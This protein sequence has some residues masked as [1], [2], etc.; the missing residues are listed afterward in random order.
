MPLAETAIGLDKQS[1]WEKLEEKK[2]W[3]EMTGR[4]LT[5][6]TVM[7]CLLYLVL[8]VLARVK[9]LLLAGSIISQ[10]LGLTLV[11]STYKQQRNDD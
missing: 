6:P 3:Q 8:V 10:Y 11:C 7:V 1:L 4:F 5:G 9:A 2:N